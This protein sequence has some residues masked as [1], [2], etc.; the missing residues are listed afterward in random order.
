MSGF[1]LPGWSALRGMFQA[2]AHAPAAARPRLPRGFSEMP[3][4]VFREASP[5]QRSA[6]L[7]RTVEK[8]ERAFRGEAATSEVA[9]PFPSTGPHGHRHRMRLKLIERGGGAL[10]DYELLEMLLFFAQPKGDTKPLAKDLINKFGSFSGVLTASPEHL[11][12]V[13][14]IGEFSVA[15]IKLVQESAVR[16][17]RAQIATGPVLN[18]MA[19][20][21]TYLQVA[22]GHEKTEHLRVLLLDS[23]NRLISDEVLSRGTINHTP[24]YPREIVKR[25]LE[26]HATALIL[27]HN[28]PSGDPHASLDDVDMSRHMKEAAAL[29]EIR[30]HDSI[31]V[32]GGK[33]FSLRNEGLL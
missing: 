29:L 31:I 17:A 15:A 28:H 23:A 16:L 14:G 19:S 30:L 32:G 13:T 10:A 33:L 27:V 18:N 21:T 26:R 2:S 24:L 9:L 1:G 20:L 7:A 4:P 22:M 8:I 3:E 5:E 25:A 6:A 12:K 11:L